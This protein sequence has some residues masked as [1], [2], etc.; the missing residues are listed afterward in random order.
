MFPREGRAGIIVEQD[1]RDIAGQTKLP[2][3]AGLSQDKHPHGRARGIRHDREDLRDPED[4]R[5]KA[6]VTGRVG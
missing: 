6:Y 2:E 3:P 4:S 5:T 1:E